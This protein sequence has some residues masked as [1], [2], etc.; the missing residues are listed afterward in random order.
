T[1]AWILRESPIRIL[2]LN[3]ASVASLVQSTFGVKLEK[4]R[5]PSWSLRSGGKSSVS[6]FAYSGRIRSLAGVPLKRDIVVLGFNHNIQS[7]FGVTR[8][9]AAALQR[10]IGTMS[11]DILSEA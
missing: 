7:S 6:G 11:E 4:T 8:E 1:L 9:V 5:M 10:W 3:G 2:V